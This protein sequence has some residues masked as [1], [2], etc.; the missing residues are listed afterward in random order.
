MAKLSLLSNRIS[1]VQEKNLKAYPF[2]F[3]NDLKSVRIDY[4]VGKINDRGQLNNTSH[5]VT[6]YLELNE[7]AINEHMDKRFFCIEEA[8]RVLF[9]NDL[10]VRVFIDSKLAFESKNGREQSSS[11]T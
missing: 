9:W 1:E 5:H 4:D 2:V 7:N 3:F 8:T 11:K 10:K 6:Y